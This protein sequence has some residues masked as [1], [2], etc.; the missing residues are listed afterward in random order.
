MRQAALMNSV[1]SGVQAALATV[2]VLTLV[3]I[4]PW[5]HL[6]GYAALGTLVTLFARFA[7]RGD[8]PKILWQC[9]GL[10]VSAVLLTGLLSAAG[11]P[12]PA[13]LI[14]LVLCTG[15]Y[16]VLAL[17]IRCGAPGPLI[18]VFAVGAALAP[19]QS[20]AEV[21]SQS[22]AT[23][24]AGLAGL[25]ICALTDRWRPQPSAQRPLPIEPHL[26]LR[27]RLV[28]ALRT[29]L[30]AGAAVLA[31]LSLEAQHPAWA[32]MGALAVMQ[33]AGLHIHMNRALQ[34]MIGSVA[35]SLLAYLL[36]SS[37]PDIAEVILWLC[38]LQIL[39]EL[40]I[41][42]NYAFGQAFVTPMA[43]L[44]TWLAAPDLSPGAIAYERVVDTVLGAGVAVLVAV[45][46]SSLEQRQQFAEHRL[47]QAA[48]RRARP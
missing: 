36:L 40:V 11:L 22:A 39:T 23:C 38:A 30:A 9:L 2:L 42:A 19:G 48:A 46:L 21:L 14:W 24:L 20:L 27:Q 8:R 12:L 31:C 47:G 3:L 5:P 28:A 6:A 26:P 10:Q 7:P 29:M 34:R 33:G 32:A 44:M 25:I 18:F 41:G 37:A 13:M 16:L 4:S 45:L 35:G 1:L 17:T 43:L 15:L